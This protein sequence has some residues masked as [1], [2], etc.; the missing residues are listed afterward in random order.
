MGSIR[1]VELRAGDPAFGDT[2]RGR[3]RLHRGTMERFGL[4]LGDA[5][6]L[7]AEAGTAAATVSPANHGEWGLWSPSQDTVYVGLAALLGETP[8]NVGDSEV[9][10]RPVTTSLPNVS[11]SKRTIRCRTPTRDGGRPPRVRRH[12]GRRRGFFLYVRQDLGADDER[13]YT[14]YCLERSVIPTVL[15]TRQAV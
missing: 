11:S 13:T 12:A 10:V 9:L 3:C 1:G 8:A 6:T 4:S 15:Q 14:S 2:I 7:T 5:V